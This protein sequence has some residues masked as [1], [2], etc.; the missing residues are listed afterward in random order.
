L[1]FSVTLPWPS[2][3]LSPN[4]RLHWASK[5][6]ATKSAREAAFWLTWEAIGGRRPGWARAKLEIEFCPPDARRRDIQNFI[7]SL[8]APVDGIADALGVNDS[9]FG[10]DFRMGSPVKGGAVLITLRAA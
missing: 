7:G 10:F 9:L 1:S 2:K 3:S 6:K 5:A 8:K 4:A